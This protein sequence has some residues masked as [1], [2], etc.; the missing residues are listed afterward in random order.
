[1]KETI[2]LFKINLN[3]INNQINIKINILNITLLLVSIV[4]LNYLS[5][6]IINKK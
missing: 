2:R 3:I 1:M 6:K 4:F 5:N